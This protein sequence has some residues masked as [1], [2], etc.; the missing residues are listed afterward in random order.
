MA[1]A[2]QCVTG[3]QSL[4]TGPEKPLWGTMR[5]SPGCIGAPKMLE[6]SVLWVIC[7]AEMYTETRNC[8]RET[9]IFPAAMPEGQSYSNFWNWG[10]D[11]V[12]VSQYFLFSLPSFSLVVV[13]SLLPTVTLFCIGD[14]YGIPKH[15]ESKNWVWGRGSLLRL[16]LNSQKSFGLNFWAVLELVTSM[17][18]LFCFCF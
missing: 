2:N 17:E 6:M 8:P 16:C 14:A 10:P 18:V 9:C 1:K 11:P 4:W 3:L 5:G 7:Q 13:H 15:I 12:H